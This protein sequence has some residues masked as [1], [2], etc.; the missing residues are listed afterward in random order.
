MSFQFLTNEINSRFPLRVTTISKTLIF[1][2]VKTISDVL[3]SVTV[4]GFH[5]TIGK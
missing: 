2:K 4:I 1:S 5:V 3:V